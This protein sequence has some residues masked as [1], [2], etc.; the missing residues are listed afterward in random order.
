MYPTDLTDAQW[1][2][3]EPF[4]GRPDPRGAV[5]KYSRRAVINAILYVNKTGCQWRML[6]ADFPKWQCVYDRFRRMQQRGVWEDICRELNKSTRQKGGA[7][8]H[9]AIC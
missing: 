4:T 3:I 8:R 7:R 9:P 2:R 6:P 5:P 1:C